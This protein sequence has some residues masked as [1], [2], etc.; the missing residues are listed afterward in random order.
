[1]NNSYFIETAQHN[2]AKIKRDTRVLLILIGICLFVAFI[3]RFFFWH[4]TERVLI[5]KSS[6]ISFETELGWPASLYGYGIFFAIAFGIGLIF[7]RTVQD[8]NK[9]AFGITNQGLMINQQYIRNAFV[10]WNNIESVEL[11]GHKDKPIIRI[12]IKDIDVLLKGQFF[13]FRTLSKSMLK[14]SRSLAIS[15]DETIGDLNKMYEIIKEKMY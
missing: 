6:G 10:P 5:T 3:S 11:K 8:I 15:K 7:V 13:V 14:D 2:F 12:K 4:Y 1:M 9:P